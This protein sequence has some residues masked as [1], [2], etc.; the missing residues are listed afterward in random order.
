MFAPET[1]IKKATAQNVILLDYS[2]GGNGYHGSSG[3]V[4]LT[5]SSQ[6]A[7]FTF[8]YTVNGIDAYDLAGSVLTGVYDSG[9]HQF[10]AFG[11]G[12][13]YRTRSWTSFTHFE[14]YK[15]SYYYGTLS[16]VYIDR[17]SCNSIGYAKVEARGSELFR[18]EHSTWW[19]AKTSVHYDYISLTVSSL[20][21]C[22][23]L[24]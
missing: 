6:G 15:I 18:V 22:S 2:I 1:N 16:G 14:S 20:V 5:V 10:I 3:T 17:S 11:K 13:N 23:T 7:L 24:P 12:Y 9:I 21:S 19:G 8:S 4:S